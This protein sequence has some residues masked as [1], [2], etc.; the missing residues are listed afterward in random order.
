MTDSFQPIP[1]TPAAVSTAGA[2]SDEQIQAIDN[3]TDQITEADF[4][5]GSYENRFQA[6][7]LHRDY[8]LDVQN[9]Y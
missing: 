7:K 4:I 5:E 9:H 3:Q 6:K 1:F 2:L 8:D